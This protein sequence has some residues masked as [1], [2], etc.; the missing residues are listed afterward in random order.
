V[1]TPPPEFGDYTLVRP[2][3]SGM[4]GHAYL[5]RDRVLTRNVAI[6]F[7]AQVA[8]DEATRQ[9][10]LI[11]ARAAARLQHPNVVTIYGVGELDSHPYLVSEYVV[12][13]TLDQLEKPLEWRRVLEI[14]LDLSRGLSAAHRREVI[15][16]DIKPANA[17][18]EDGGTAKLLDFGL[19]KLLDS[20]PPKE[21]APAV[22]LPTPPPI[23]L[24]AATI[25]PENIALP[26]RGLAAATWM[27]A[28]I[29]EIAGPRQLTQAGALMGTPDYM[30]PEVWRGDGGSKQSDVY[31]L[32]A[33]LF[34]L[35]SG[36]APYA[37]V[38][39]D[40]LQE[41]VQSSEAP[42]LSLLTS[43]VD[44]RFSAIVDR[45]LSR[46]PE[47][48]YESA[49]ALLA[50]LEE[51]AHRVHGVELPDGNP[52]P[53]LRAFEASH[54]ALFFGRSGEVEAILE[55]MRSD[56]FVLIAGDSGT[57]KSSLS[58]AAVLPRA[59]GGGLEGGRTWTVSS[60]T[61]GRHPLGALATMLGERLGMSPTSIETMLANDPS[62]VVFEMTRRLGSA[63]GLVCFFDQLEELVTN[64][65]PEEARVVEGFIALLLRGVPGIK[66]LATIRADTLSRLA[67]LRS[68]GDEISHALYI[69]RPLS[70]DRIGDVI[71]GPAEASG[72]QFES[73]ELID[74]L[75]EDTASA[76]GGLP[77]LQFALHQ[78]WDDRD[79]KRSTITRAA[80]EAMGGIAGALAK[81]ADA[82]LEGLAPK[83]RAIARRVFLRLVSADGRAIRPTNA[84]LALE[85]DE[86][87]AVLD[88]LIAGRL[89]TALEAE[90]G[91]T[92]AIAH[93]VLLRAW[94]PLRRWIADD[95]D[96]RFIR[97]RI[98]RATAEW[99][100][101]GRKKEALFSKRQLE[102][103]KVVAAE[104]L[105]SD[106]RA[107]IGS[108]KRTLRRKRLIRWTGALS[109]PV[110]ILLLI[111]AS[112]IIA[113]RQIAAKI[114]RH[115]ASSDSAIGLA[116]AD[117]SA[118]EQAKKAA[119]ARFDAQDRG[120]GE[121]SWSAALEA[122]EKAKKN[123]QEA[124]RSIEAGLVV[125]PTRKDVR[126]RFLDVLLDR[127][128][129]E[130]GARAYA[131]RNELIDRLT[132]YDEGGARF[133]AWNRKA[134]LRI[135]TARGGSLAIDRYETPLVRGARVLRR[136]VEKRVVVPP[137]L[138]L[139]AGSYLVT[140][141][142]PDR[143]TIRYPVLLGR[144]ETLEV[145]LDPPRA[146][147]VPK[148]FVFVPAG[149]ALFG[150]TAD[151]ESRKG[152]F[153][154]VPVHEVTTQA[155][156]ISRTE[157]TFAEWIA[158][159]D[160]LPSAER[161]KRTPGIPDRIQTGS[162]RLEAAGT[163][164]GSWR[165]VYKSA[166]DVHRVA[167]G[168]PLHYPKRD[169]RQEEHW[170]RFPVTAISAEDAEAFT[171]WLSET[172]RI[173]GARLCTEYE[174]ERAA[175]GAD[176]RE[177]PHGDVI[178]PDDANFDETYARDPGG[179][180][181]DEVGAHPASES[182]FGVQDMAG[183]AFE[184]TRSSLAAN[185]YVGRGGSYCYD[186]K[187]IRVTNRAVSVGTLRDPSLG[188]RVCATYV[189]PTL[190]SRPTP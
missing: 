131:A 148:G 13:K 62:T 26:P 118:W 28:S 99:I 65:V 143:Q 133:R 112:R 73:P 77:L 40:R 42:R 138:E 68:I 170:E 162:V 87:R 121:K 80:L 27:P 8:P 24:V 2:L 106:E 58:K 171:T 109:M 159:L 180:G 139:D 94:Q 165:L 189:Q 157:A 101:L 119:D 190:A 57:G 168:E 38:A 113:S 9:R 175:R 114:E 63:V 32:G 97:E 5:A 11:E 173:P 48:R 163:G 89:I 149:R 146:D 49:E 83:Q 12:G 76:N 188:L 90:D 59:V 142:S 103:T 116:K 122:R 34:E 44:L 135:D 123:Y 14:G 130:E 56:P 20:S 124:T 156:L 18:L 140:L 17:I 81:H 145:K 86:A 127:A 37:D 66:V 92:Y 61:L 100:R 91:S 3:G 108:S 126:A 185:E 96:A 107:F 88:A 111:A 144:G 169:R 137:D 85:G 7:I 167:R 181:L 52:Y 160:S 33:V 154:T 46:A 176:D 136:V 95:D 82:V 51:L 105:G 55:R 161:Q 70:R 98:T 35:A 150:S 84:E 47:M 23:A 43:G 147:E 172:G 53:G 132:L 164:A 115:L 6:K 125:D 31:A 45:C 153:D 110:T 74:R 166:T 16:R 158:F 21:R 128:E 75:V 39:V 1:W 186:T 120:A 15:H 178:L 69:L 104:S 152:F 30:S 184:W 64:A 67:A 22:P 71:V 141:E 177:F 151:E 19:A 72:V 182:P 50:A 93:E 187:T 25:A 183:N 117:R 78:L 174:W 134:R 10:F 4:R 155:Y 41:V 102:E 79:E 129:F 179:M 60:C 36:R 29:E 54:R